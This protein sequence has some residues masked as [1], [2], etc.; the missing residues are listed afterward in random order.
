MLHRNP[1]L[2]A[3][4]PRHHPGTR[5]LGVACAI[6]IAVSACGSSSKSKS[7]GGSTTK[8]LVIGV[9][10]SLSGDF[11]DPGKAVKRG[12]E[13]WADTVNAKGG[14]LGR[15]VEMKIVDDTSSPNQVITNYTNLITQDKVDLVFGPFSSLLTIPASQVAARITT[16]SSSPPAAGRRSSPN[17]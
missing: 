5:S 8:P 12:Y 15:K 1:S 9:S 4:R 2:T 14:L 13:L 3:R 7:F 10:V 11:A 6:A 16:R 17:T